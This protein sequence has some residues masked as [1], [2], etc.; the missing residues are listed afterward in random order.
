MQVESYRSYTYIF[1]KH[2][3]KRY[4]FSVLPLKKKNVQKHEMFCGTIFTILVV[5]Y[6]RSRRTKNTIVHCDP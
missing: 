2:K 5:I 1:D 6:T 4:L 3:F